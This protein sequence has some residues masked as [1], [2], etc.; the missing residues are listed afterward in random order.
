MKE[1]IDE[2]RSRT[3]KL[4]DITRKDINKYS[5]QRK[6]VF[7]Y[8]KDCKEDIKSELDEWENYINYFEKIIKEQ[9]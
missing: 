5:E 3:V 7:L 4:L 6:K 9:Q 8:Y 2:L 1:R